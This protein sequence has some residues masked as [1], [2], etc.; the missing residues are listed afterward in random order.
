MKEKLL[1]TLALIGLLE[2]LFYIIFMFSEVGYA[3]AGNKL[4]K[5]FLLC[6]KVCFIHIF[7]CDERHLE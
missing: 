2:T 4:L 3:T 1:I 6:F 7:F 5:Q